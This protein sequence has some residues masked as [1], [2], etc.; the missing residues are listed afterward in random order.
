MDSSSKPDVQFCFERILPDLQGTVRYIGESTSLKQDHHSKLIWLSKQLNS[1]KNEVIRLLDVSIDEAHILYFVKWLAEGK[2]TYYELSGVV[3][4]VE[5]SLSHL[6]DLVEF[7]LAS[8]GSVREFDKLFDLIEDCTGLATELKVRLNSKMPLLEASLEF[9]EIFND[10]INTLGTVIDMN[11][12]SCF[13]LQEERFTSPVRHPPSFTLKQVIRL[14]ASYTDTAE[15]T[16]P[17]FSPVEELLSKNYLDIK[18]TVPPISKSLTEILPARIDHFSKRTVIH[19][20]YLTRLLKEKHKEVLDKYSIMVKEVRELKRELVDKRWNL[21][22]LNLNHELQS[23]LDEIKLLESKVHDYENNLEIQEKVKEQLR[24]KTS[25]VTKT[26]SIIYRALE[27]SLLDVDIASTTN[28]LAQRWLDMRPQNDR[29]LSSSSSLVEETSCDSLSSRLRSLSMGSTETAET[30]Q[31]S[32]PPPP[33]RGKFG[34]LLLKKMNI[35]PVMVTSPTTNELNN[36]FIDNLPLPKDEV[37]SRSSS[38]SMEPIPPIAFKKSEILLERPRT[39]IERPSSPS[40]VPKT[41]VANNNITNMVISTERFAH[42]RDLEKS[43]ISYYAQMPTH[44]PKLRNHKSSKYNSLLLN[45]SDLPYESY[46]FKQKNSD[47][48]GHL[49]PPTPLADILITKT[50]M[51]ATHDNSIMTKI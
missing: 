39:P 7:V 47:G 21:L 9:N 16:I 27:F 32:V 34:A 2:K 30:E 4:K 6:L 40:E 24:S 41:P 36:P 45:K 3:N 29:V 23:I 5:P 51:L 26:F 22:F 13:E 43:K 18:R 50:R 15:A 25:T 33:A 20:G 48:R 49:I 28:E 19:I 44:I 37:I 1:I 11:I 10:N 42:L 14:L 38:L 12:N 8:S 17:T 35:K 31:S 46:T